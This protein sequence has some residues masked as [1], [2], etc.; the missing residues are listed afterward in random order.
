MPESIDRWYCPWCG[1]Y[2]LITEDCACEPC[3]GCGARAYWACKC[4]PCWLCGGNDCTCRQED[5]AFLQF[6]P[7][8]IC[9]FCGRGLWDDGWCICTK[10]PGIPF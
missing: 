10:S 7:L 9:M 3:E 4:R 1:K 8:S 6:A 5:A 2:F